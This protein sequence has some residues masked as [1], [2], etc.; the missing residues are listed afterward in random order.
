MPHKDVQLFTAEHRRK[1]SDVESKNLLI[2]LVEDIPINQRV[3]AHILQK[4]GHTVE[5]AANGR[6]AIAMHDSKEYDAIL[7]DIHM[8]EMDGLEATKHIRKIEE[9]TKKHI[10]IIA[11]TARVLIKDRETC[12]EAGMD[13]YISKP[14]TKDELA[15]KL[16]IF[17][18][19]SAEALD[20]SKN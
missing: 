6:E 18:P 11:L 10:P 17:F 16:A 15:K 8:P 2:L 20:I 9:K 13:D 1:H 19:P 12:L 7:M 4:L 3:S 14:V 5:I